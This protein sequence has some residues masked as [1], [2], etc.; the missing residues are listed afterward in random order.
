MPEPD[1]VLNQRTPFL[2]LDLLYGRGPFSQDSALYETDGVSFKLGAI[3]TE[4]GQ[5]FDIPLDPSTSQPLLAD[6][7]NNENLIIRQ[8]H[9]IFLKLHNIA[10]AELRG[11][12]PDRE[13][14]EKA[15]ERVRWQYQWLVRRDYLSRICNE[16]IYKDIVGSGNTRIDWGNC[17]AIPVEFAHAAARF[18]HSMVRPKYDL[19]RTKLDFPVRRIFE[20]AHKPKELDPALA[21]DWRRFTRDPA[22]S[23]DTAIVGALFRL[24]ATTISLCVASSSPAEPDALPVRTAY[25]GVAMKIPT[26]EAVCAGLDPSAVLSEPH[27]NAGY[28]PFKPLRD[29]QLVG[30]TPLWGTMYCWKRN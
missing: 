3:K 1:D 28:D 18:G 22:N 7:R 17:F 26:G 13:L 15:R 2:D 20:E 24:S 30:R 21:I 19:N 6:N 25:R 5:T 9:A 12:V 8:I 27:S 23:I 10:V 11:R 29:L 14:F 16:E 4:E